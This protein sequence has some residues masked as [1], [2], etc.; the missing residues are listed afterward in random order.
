MSTPAAEDQHR[1]DARSLYLELL[2]RTLTRLVTVDETAPI[3]TSPLDKTRKALFGAINKY[4]VPAYFKVAGKLQFPESVV[5]FVI[6]PT[7]RGLKR[8][9]PSFDPAK[10]VDGRDWPKDGESMIGLR[11][12]DNIQ[13]CA[14]D[15]INSNVPGDFIETGVWRGG[16]CIFMR[17]IVAAYQSNRTVWV[18]DSFR[19]L[20]KPD[21]A[22]YPA[23]KD[24]GHWAFSGELAIS[25]E[26][27]QSNFRRYGLLDDQ[28]KFLR[29]W[30]K[31]TLPS[32]PIKQLALMRLDGDLYE[33]TMDSL[34]ALYPKLSVGGYVII[35]DYNAL[36]PCKE[37]VDTYR[38][39]NGITDP[40]LEVDWS[41]VY[42][43]RTR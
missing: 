19:G 29:G 40:I 13:Q 27:V 33:S 9:A 1:A 42:W 26:Q 31:D 43:K 34:T 36:A 37:A 2:K 4:A 6:G 12:L 16:A 3:A 21:T 23:D 35:D 30:F 22:K 41:R 28:V 32:A 39:R 8:L 11:A 18:A 10:R 17:G 14:V 7:H 24:D 15:V 25:L 38:E 5:K 20:P